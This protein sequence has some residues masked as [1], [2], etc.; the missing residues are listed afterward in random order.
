MCV[1]VRERLKVNIK[2]FAAR[3]PSGGTP[4]NKLRDVFSRR[5]SAAGT[6]FAASFRRLAARPLGVLT[7]SLDQSPAP[8]METRRDEIVEKREGRSR[9]L[10][11][12]ILHRKCTRRPCGNP[13]A[14]SAYFKRRKSGSVGQYRG[15][16]GPRS[17]PPARKRV[18]PPAGDFSKFT[19]AQI[20]ALRPRGS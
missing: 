2:K 4:V 13:R 12:K 8:S 16:C 15:C 20:T 19:I 10:K 6:C 11:T 18:F 7:L 14:G 17:I 3:A 1:C 5:R 9:N